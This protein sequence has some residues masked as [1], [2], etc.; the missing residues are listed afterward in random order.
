MNQ[1]GQIQGPHWFNHNQ[2]SQRINTLHSI[3]NM[4]A[5]RQRIAAV[6]IE[7]WNLLFNF[8]GT[9]RNF[10][11]VTRVWLTRIQLRKVSTKATNSAI[12]RI[13]FS[14][15][16]S[17]PNS[18]VVSLTKGYKQTTNFK[19]LFI[20]MKTNFTANF[21]LKI[22]WCAF[23]FRRT[24]V[25]KTRIQLG[26][27][28]FK[29]SFTAFLLENQFFVCIIRMKHACI[30]HCSANHNQ[31]FIFVC[32]KTITRFYQQNRVIE[33][34]GNMEKRMTKAK[35]DIARCNLRSVVINRRFVVERCVT[36][37]DFHR[38]AE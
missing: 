29:S 24:I 3:H 15:R 34:N 1:S 13:F 16:T 37:L 21:V 4:W 20:K 38:I 14:K 18:S 17:S 35:D 27:M 31:F 10:M 9:N 28:L 36:E 32:L 30:G 23:R 22:F 6:M 25:G 5:H 7:K 11:D 33:N 19:C 12:Q 8:I 26:D 2:N